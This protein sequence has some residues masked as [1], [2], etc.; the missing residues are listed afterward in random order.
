MRETNFS[1]S[2]K[3]ILGNKCVLRGAHTGLNVVVILFFENCGQLWE[4]GEE[5]VQA[6]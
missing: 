3:W 1:Q 4:S 5:E 6:W 2:R